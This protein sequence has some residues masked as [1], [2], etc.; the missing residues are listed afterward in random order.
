M[1]CQGVQRTCQGCLPPR[2]QWSRCPGLCGKEQAN[3]VGN[4]CCRA[5]QGH[6][7]SAMQA[8]KYMAET[9]RAVV[10]GI[11]IITA[12]ISIAHLINKHQ[13][14]NGKHHPKMLWL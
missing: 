5:R 11:V 1:A 10:D 8:V 12:S 14:V 7:R 3:V 6:A 4:L 9:L 2:L 13:K